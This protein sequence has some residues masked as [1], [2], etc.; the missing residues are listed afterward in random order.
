MSRHS[1]IRRRYEQ[2][3]DNAPQYRH[4]T[5]RR[6]FDS[7]SA[8]QLFTLPLQEEHF[9]FDLNCTAESI[10]HRILSKS[11]I[12]ALSTDQQAALHTKVFRCDRLLPISSQPWC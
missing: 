6:A 3:E 9:T 10:W 7:D 5:W 11:Y 2:F 12:S 1:P 4:G 8:R